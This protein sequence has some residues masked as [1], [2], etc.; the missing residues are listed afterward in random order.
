[1]RLFLFLI[2]VFISACGIARPIE[3]YYEARRLLWSVVYANG[4]ETLYCGQKFGAD[5]PKSI[6][7]EHV[8]PM[9]WVMNELKCGTRQS[10][11]LDSIRFNLIEGDLHN[12]YPARKNLNR[13]R[14]SYPFGLI[15]GEKRQFGKCDFEIDRRKRQVEPREEVRGDIA[16]AMLYMS[17]TYNITL[18]ERQRA[19]LK[20]WHKAD[21]P[22]AEEQRRNDVI[23]ILQGNRNP[24]IDQ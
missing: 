5:H 17:D 16:R 9:G 12:L 3:N 14:S 10:C 8:L 4:G 6:N 18:F 22:D 24:L 21:P 2:I 19:L 1:M 15:K 13:E 23:E 11:R 7:V 20:K